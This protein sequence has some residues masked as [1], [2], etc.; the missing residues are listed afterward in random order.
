MVG[1]GGSLMDV[2]KYLKT[3]STM[4]AEVPTSCPWLNTL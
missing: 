4:S 3:D 2:S 1:A